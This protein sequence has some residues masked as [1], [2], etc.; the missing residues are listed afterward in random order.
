M[1]QTLGDTRP[2]AMP[3]VLIHGDLALD[4]VLI[5]ESGRLSLI[6]WSGGDSGDYRNDIAL[7]LQTESEITLM[8]EEVLAFYKGYGCAPLGRDTRHWFELLYEFF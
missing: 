2:L 4:N 1:L 3:E 5:D 6:D 7:A 8:E